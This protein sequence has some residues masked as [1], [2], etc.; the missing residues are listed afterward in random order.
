MSKETTEFPVLID[1]STET[2]SIDVDNGM[3]VHG[4]F[5]AGAGPT[6]DPNLK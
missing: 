6:F 5:F 1:F 4:I 3:A 2:G